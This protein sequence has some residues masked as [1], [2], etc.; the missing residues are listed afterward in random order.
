M[1][2]S[3]VAGGRQ[4]GKTTKAV[5]WVRRGCRTHRSPGWSRVLLVSTTTEA[6]W[7][8]Q[9]FKLDRGQVWVADDWRHRVRGWGG[10]GAP[11]CEVA[12]DDA[13]RILRELVGRRG[14]LGL[15]VVE[16]AMW[17]M[18]CEAPDWEQANATL[19]HRVRQLEAEVA[20]L[21]SRKTDQRG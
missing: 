17:H 21:R 16:G 8:C 11:E 2:V 5:E 1:T 9:E 19:K 4:T 12:V 13:E 3:I 15:V 7:V 14:T 10:D 6:R 18:A 20:D